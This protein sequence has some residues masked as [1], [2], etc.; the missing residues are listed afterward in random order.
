MKEKFERLPK[1]EHDFLMSQARLIAQDLEEK[2]VAGIYRLLRLGGVNVVLE[3]TEE[4]KKIQE[5]GGMMTNDGTRKKTTGGIFFRL[6]KTRVA[7]TYK[8]STTP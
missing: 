6:A 3:A 1:K 2:N 8:R 4:A 7:S 5:S